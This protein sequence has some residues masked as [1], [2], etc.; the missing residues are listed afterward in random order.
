MALFGRKRRFVVTN[1][2]V[3]VDES[4]FSAILTLCSGAQKRIADSGDDFAVASEELAHVAGGL[5]DRLDSATHAACF[6]E[7][8]DDEGEAGDHGQ[9]CFAELSTR[10]LAAPDDAR[11]A[12]EQ[13]MPG[14]RRAVVMLTV[15]YEGERPALENPPD[16]VVAL[17]E[18]LTQLVALHHMDALL[19]AHVHH[20]PSHPEDKLTD[21]QMLANYPELLSL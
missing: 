20:A 3:A 10:Y 2:F 11:G 18:A 8:F 1:L 4:A 7:V 12:P 6:G 5:L 16:S 15:G 19:L 14:E 9:E 21:E 17:K 13:A